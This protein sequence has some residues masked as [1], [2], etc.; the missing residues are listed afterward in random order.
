MATA[1]EPLLFDGIS[2]KVGSSVFVRTRRGQVVRVRVRPANPQTVS[3]TAFRDLMAAAASAGSALSASDAAL[4]KV[5]AALIVKRNRTNGSIYSP[6]WFNYFCSLAVPYLLFNP[7]GSA[8]TSPP[9]A[10][11]DAPQFAVSVS[12][13]AGSVTFSGAVVQPADTTTEFY[14]QPLVSP[15]RS[16]LLDKY[17]FQS[18]DAFPVGGSHDVVVSADPGLYAAAVKFGKISTGQEGTLLELGKVTVT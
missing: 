10:P 12:G 18:V 1:G 17:R 6:S 3:Q 7:G 15:N 8:P 16:P 9:A 11:F 5:A 13:G 4:W 14:L 2:G